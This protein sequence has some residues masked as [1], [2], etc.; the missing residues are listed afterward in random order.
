M[1][2]A[3][4]AGIGFSFHLDRRS[5]SACAIGGSLAARHDAC[6]RRGARR[7]RFKPGIPPFLIRSWSSAA[8][9]HP[10]H[11][12][13]GASRAVRRILPI[14]WLLRRLDLHHFVHVPA[15]LKKGAAHGLLNV[16][17]LPP[18]APLSA[19]RRFSRKRPCRRPAWCARPGFMLNV[20]NDA[21]LGGPPALS[22]FCPGAAAHDRTGRAA[23]AR[24]NTGISAIIDPYGRVLGQCRWAEG[25]IDGV[26]PG[27]IGAPPFARAPFLAGI[28]A[29]LYALRFSRAKGF[30]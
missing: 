27:K 28:F 9:D 21:G 1:S 24:A 25:V 16:P 18:A 23:A 30:V 6:H 14:E 15:A 13:Q 17:G 4:L 11:L 7:G 10:R 2:S 5:A 26:L 29:W 20:T 22:A 8:A 3:H 12:R 19:M